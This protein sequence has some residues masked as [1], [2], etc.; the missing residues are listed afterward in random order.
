MLKKKTR[1]IT[2]FLGTQ[3][4]IN[5]FLISQKICLILGNTAREKPI[6]NP[7]NI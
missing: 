1:K 4:K 7:Y 5:E 6:E 3:K 2:I